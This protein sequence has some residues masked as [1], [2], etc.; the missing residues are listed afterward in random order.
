VLEIDEEEMSMTVK[1]DT[2]LSKAKS[3][4]KSTK[5]MKINPDKISFVDDYSVI[6]RTER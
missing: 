6:K 2:G 5:R 4:K 3:T 1:W